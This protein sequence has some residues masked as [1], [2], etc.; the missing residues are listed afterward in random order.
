MN[1]EM[2]QYGLLSI[3]SSG[4]I[5]RHLMTDTL[6]A[7]RA[8][9]EENNWKFLDENQFSWDLELTPVKAISK[10]ISGESCICF[11]FFEDSGLMSMSLEGTFGNN[12][13]CSDMTLVPM[14]LEQPALEEISDLWS[15]EKEK[16]L[17]LPAGES[18]SS[19][20]WWVGSPKYAGEKYHFTHAYD[21]IVEAVA[22]GHTPAL[23]QDTYAIYQIKSGD[24]FHNLRFL[25]YSA[26]NKQDLAISAQNYDKV[27]EAP[28]PAYTEK[29]AL[30]EG[31]YY[32]FNRN[33]PSDFTGHSLSVSDV[34]VLTEQGHQSAYYVDSIG[35]K[36]IPEFI[37]TLPE[38]TL[39]SLT[40]QI[41]G[42][43][44]KA[45]PRSAPNL[46]E[47]EREL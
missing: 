18:C 29:N 40:Q 7:C 14:S 9:A 41:S 42:A 13:N 31:L 3:V 4:G 39:S 30:L 47:A 5:S 19:S 20:G 33:H 22:K 36:E 10:E 45:G 16:E 6:D 25:S 2:Q 26:A 11:E 23:R 34:V 15:C 1:Q 12:I 21:S 37:K 24:A 38:K 35:F 32:Q 8:F 44:S 17:G 46:P 28:L 27:Y 43:K